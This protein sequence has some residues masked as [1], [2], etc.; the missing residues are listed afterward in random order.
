MLLLRLLWLQNQTRRAVRGRRADDAAGLAREALETCIVGLYCLFSE[1]AVDKL[2]AANYRAAGK[3]VSYMASTGLVS[4]A[5]IGSAVA[6]LGTT[7]PNLNIA[8]LADAL[9]YKHDMPF[10]R[11]LYGAYYARFRTF[12]STPMLSPSPGTSAGTTRPGV[13]QGP[14]GRAGQQRA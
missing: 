3:A 14:S 6:S 7:G 2:A 1:D 13:S 5:A 11:E 9:A 4:A 12:M 8:A 10:V